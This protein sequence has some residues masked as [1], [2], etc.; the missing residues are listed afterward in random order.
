[1]L[2][3]GSRQPHCPG[4]TRHPTKRS[5]NERLVYISC[6]RIAGSRSQD[7]RTM[8]CSC[9][10]RTFRPGGRYSPALAADRRRSGLWPRGGNTLRAGSPL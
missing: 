4:R 6:Q 2:H 8:N 3:G 9:L 1:M 7:V 10:L 5:I